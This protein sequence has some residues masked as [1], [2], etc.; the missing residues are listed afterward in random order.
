M[1][2]DIDIYVEMF[3]IDRLIYDLILGLGFFVKQVFVFIQCTVDFI[4]EFG[5]QILGL[6]FVLLYFIVVNIDR[7]FDFVNFRQWVIFLFWFIVLLKKVFRNGNVKNMVIINYCKC[8]IY[9][10]V[11]V[12]IVLKVYYLYYKL[13]NRYLINIQIFRLV[14]QKY[15]IWKYII[16]FFVIDEFL[17]YIWYFLIV[18]MRNGFDSGLRSEMKDVFILFLIQF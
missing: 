6:N 18:Y 9:M 14:N 1:L 16:I 13:I 2:F 5:F 15:C 12:N 7:V 8:F 10:Y 4:C 11:V 17:F 3:V